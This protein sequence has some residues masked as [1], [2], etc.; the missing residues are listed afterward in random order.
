[1]PGLLA[2]QDDLP[3]VLATYRR[4][5][6]LLPGTIKSFWP[7]NRQTRA[8]VFYQASNETGRHSKAGRPGGLSSESAGLTPL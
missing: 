1:M 3:R 8:E 7:L 2:N 5:E 4:A 6:Q